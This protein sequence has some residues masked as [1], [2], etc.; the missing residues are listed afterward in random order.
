MIRY[1]R[2]ASVGTQRVRFAALLP[3]WPR[4][5]TAPQLF[6]ASFLVLILFGTLGLRVL[7][8]LYTGPPLGWLDA[9]FTAT[10]AVCV[11]GLI[12]VDT[13]TYFTPFGQAF[14]LL[15][16]QLGGL[17][18]ITLTTIIILALGRRLSVTQESVSGGVA[19][20]VP[21]IDL[22]RL[23]RNVVLFT[24]AFEAL[25]ALVLLAAWAPA[26]GVRAAAWA[27][28]F[29]AV[30]AF[31]NAGFSI[32]PDSLVG[33]RTAP[34]TLVTIMVLIVVGGIGFLTM[35]EL[36]FR[37]ASRRRRLRRHTDELVP[38][39]SLHSRLV[40]GVTA[41]L[42]VGG[43]LFFTVF[44]WGLTLAELPWWA[45]VVNGL[46][47]SVTSRTAGFNTIDHDAASAGT[48]FLTVL[49]MF[50]GGSPGSTAGGVKTTTA[51]L[52]GLLAWSRLMGR[53]HVSLLG[54][55]VPDETVQRAVGL[56]VVAFGVTTFAI[57]A[58]TAT[59]MG[60]VH[61]G[62]AEAGFMAYMFE[63]VSAFNTV[64]LSMGVTLELSPAGRFITTLLMYAGR[65]GPLTFAAAIALRPHDARVFRYAHE[66]VVIG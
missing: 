12:V 48:N 30:S 37:R 53:R 61:H 21:H 23:M 41:V 38:R 20:V 66:D 29:H 35:D 2:N 34:L 4:R 33:F 24:L 28:L 18:L 31:C 5:L 45:R 6:V 56:F 47:I 62:G 19:D 11:T 25:G 51:A 44:E 43:W 1:R 36:Y 39:L 54:R 63:A 22:R 8:G 40:L 58:F 9:L 16:I 55:T 27:A 59:E 32:F 13:A 60:F 7:P 15:L 49:L 42:I 65:V 64:G 52:L 3:G 26:L 50:I 57:F 17:G 10:S 14:L 46:F